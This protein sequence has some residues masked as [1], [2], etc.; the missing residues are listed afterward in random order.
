MINTTTLDTQLEIT[1]RHIELPLTSLHYATVGKGP[2]LVMVPAT[3]SHLDRWKALTQFMG[4]RFT[5]HFFELPGHGQSSAF[6]E[7]YNSQL[8]A[9]TIEHFVDAMGYERFS[10]MGFSF[11]G[12]LTMKTL[13][14]L[15]DRID[16]IVLVSPCMTPKAITLPRLRKKM[17]R[18]GMKILNR[19]AIVNAVA[20]AFQNKHIGYNAARFIRKLGEVEET[21]PL[22]EQ[23]KTIPTSTYHVITNQMEEIFNIGF[24][25]PARPYT[26][27]CYFAMSIYDPLLDFDTTVAVAK[28]N[29]I[30]FEMTRLY[31]PY[32]QAPETP[33]LDDLNRDYDHLLQMIQL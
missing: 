16:R 15:Q 20:A 11:G 30:N 24:E 5:A 13:A 17:L 18:T 19:P 4:Q 27:P 14:H 12:I 10:L 7:P 31:L 21:I 8:V 23:L 6:T 9:E 32:H 3:V 33:S 26:I 29:F 2:P 25:H 1:Y 22:E 28:E